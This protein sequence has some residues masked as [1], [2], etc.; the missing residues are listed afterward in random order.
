MNKNLDKFHRHEALDRTHLLLNNV[1]EY[2]LQHPYVASN[3]EYNQLAQ[4]AF[5]KLHRL[6]QLIGTED[7]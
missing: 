1:D 3:E 6:Y 7:A 2:L 4:E 5:D